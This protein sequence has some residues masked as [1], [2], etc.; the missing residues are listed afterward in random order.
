MKFLETLRAEN[1]II[2]YLEYH[3]NRIK[4]SCGHDIELNL[5][6]PPIGVW[7]VRIIYSE[8]IESIEYIPY[9]QTSIKSLQ[10]VEADSLNY[11]Y[12]FENR[13]ELNN[14]F[15]QRK[16]ADD[17][18]IVKNSLITDTTIANIAFFDGNDWLTPT[19]PLLKGT[20]RARLIDDNFLIQANIKAN[21]VKYFKKFA[22]MNS[23]IGF[24]E[25][26]NG[27]IHPC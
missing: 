9:I 7:R 25:I 22:L 21:E 2:K 16:S 24:L 18:L 14:L 20:T 10:M 19:Y 11:S 12:K 13:D 15:T 27:I 4:S 1:G 23:L 3:K 8:K 26:Q 6:P 17:V 5:D